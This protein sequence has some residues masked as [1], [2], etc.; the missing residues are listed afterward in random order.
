MAGKRKVSHIHNKERGS[1]L[2]SPSTSES[3]EKNYIIYVY[4]H[5]KNS[6]NF[7]N[8]VTRSGEF[9]EDDSF[10][11]I[12]SRA[13]VKMFGKQSKNHGTHGA[14]TLPGSFKR[15]M[16]KSLYMNQL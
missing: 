7:V 4:L 5:M 10:D 14:T 12:M 11:C 13:N 2:Q 3:V 16:S 1:L 8:F 6:Q 9:A 15:N